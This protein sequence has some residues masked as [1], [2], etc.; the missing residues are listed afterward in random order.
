MRHFVDALATV[1][2]QTVS[3]HRFY[4]LAQKYETYADQFLGQSNP[5]QIQQFVFSLQTFFASP[6]WDKRVYEA[7]MR[8]NSLSDDEDTMSLAEYLETPET[9]VTVTTLANTTEYLRQNLYM[10]ASEECLR[11]IQKVPS[12]LP[13]HARLAEVLLKQNRTE[14]AI[15]KYSYIARVYQMRGQPDQAINTLQRILKLAPMD[16]TV[17][18]N[19]IDLYVAGGGVERALDEYLVL[20]DSYYQLAQVDRSLEKYQEAIRLAEQVADSSQP[21]KEHALLRMADIYNQRFDWSRSAAAIE[22]LRKIKPDDEALIRQLVELYF[23]QGKNSEGLRL[24]DQ[25]LGIYQRQS[26]AKTLE[27][28]PELVSSFP[29]ELQL[30]QRLAVAYV[31]NN[32][33]DKAI[34]EYDTLGEMQLEQGLREQAIQTV[35][36]IINLGPED[37]EGYQKLLAQ[38]SGGAY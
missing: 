15:T 3:G 10:S 19:L 36:A 24:V 16:V 14:D 21:W 25:L 34:A 27:L 17:R 11:A 28:L 35:Q 26:P 13:L 31:Q 6:D 5:E 8:M 12:F 4:E 2:M 23:K 20:A 7:R 32:M 37:V 38:I 29:N 18:A 33:V 1:D 22:Q 9:E 30:R